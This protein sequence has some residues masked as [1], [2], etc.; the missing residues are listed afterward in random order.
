MGSNRFF[1]A[2]AALLLL[3]S[4][5]SAQKVVSVTIPKAGWVTLVLKDT[6]GR[7]VDQVMTSQ[8]VP[9]AGAL[10]V[11][12]DLFGAGTVYYPSVAGT[13]RSDGSYTWQD[14][15]LTPGTYVLQGVVRD[16]WV[17]YYNAD[18]TTTNMVPWP[19]ASGRGANLADHNPPQGMACFAAP[20]AWSTTRAVCLVTSATAEAGTNYAAFAVDTVWT[21]LWEGPNT[22]SAPA[23]LAVDSADGASSI[24]AYGAFYFKNESVPEG[25]SEGKH[26]DLFTIEDDRDINRYITSV[27]IPGSAVYAG[28]DRG[29]V[30]LAVNNQRWIVALNDRVY[31]FNSSRAITDSLTA[32]LTGLAWNGGTLYATREDGV[33]AAY[34]SFSHA[35]CDLGAAATLVSGLD[36]PSDLALKG[37]SLYVSEWGT[38]NR[39]RVF[40]RSGTAVRQIGTTGALQV[41]TYNPTQMQRPAQV[42]FY[43]DRVC[44]AESEYT[45]KR[46]V[47]FNM[48][49]AATVTNLDGWWYG[50]GSYSP[51][52]VLL[53]ENTFVYCSQGGDCTEWD[54]DKG[55]TLAN[56]ARSNRHP[57]AVLYRVS[58]GLYPDYFEPY[59]DRYVV[60]GT[61][62]FMVACGSS[63][64]ACGTSAVWYLKD[65]HYLKPRGAHGR[66]WGA[67][68][69]TTEYADA[70]NDLD[71]FSDNTV[72]VWS[73]SDGDGVIDAAPGDSDTNLD[74]PA[75]DEIACNLLGSVNGRA[76]YVSPYD[77]A[78]ANSAGAYM[79]PPTVG[80][81]REPRWGAPS[82]LWSSPT[83]YAFN[84]GDA[85]ANSG[86]YLSTSYGDV[87]IGP[88]ATAADR[89]ICAMR[90]PF[91]CFKN[92]V[93]LLRFDVSGPFGDAPTLPPPNQ[94]RVVEPQ[95]AFGPVRI[96]GGTRPEFIWG[97]DTD[98][99]AVCLWTIDALGLGCLRFDQRVAFA[100]NDDVPPEEWYEVTEKGEHWYGQMFAHGDSLYYCGGKEYSGCH[101]VPDP[102]IL[103]LDSTTI[104][105]TSGEIAA[106]RLAA[107]AVDSFLVNWQLFTRDTCAVMVTAVAPR[108]DGLDERPAYTRC[109]ISESRGT[110]GSLA[111][112]ADSLYYFVGI[113]RDAYSL[114][115]PGRSQWQEAFL[116]GGLLDLVLWD[117]IGTSARF[118]M[119]D[120]PSPTPGQDIGVR[121]VADSDARLVGGSSFLY[122]SPVASQ[123]VEDASL[124]PARVVCSDVGCEGV[125]DRDLLHFTFAAGDTL[126]GD[127][128]Y[129]VTDSVEAAFRD[130]ANSY[131]VMVSDA[132]EE[133]TPTDSLNGYLAFVADDLEQSASWYAF[134]THGGASGSAN[135]EAGDVDT[136]RMDITA[137]GGLY[138]GYAASVLSAQYTATGAD[139]LASYVEPLSGCSALGQGG[140]YV[141]QD[142]H[143]REAFAS[144]QRS[145]RSIFVVTRA[146]NALALITTSV[147]VAPS[148]RARLRAVADPVADTV[149]LQYDAGAG[150][151][152]LATESLTLTAPYVMALTSSSSSPCTID[153]TDVDVP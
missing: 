124:Y 28:G 74:S 46:F 39:V 24:T 37:D 135:Y 150:W 56:G 133:S 26:I 8:Y 76:W 3:A 89:I 65:G 12:L 44:V 47:C 83:N 18:A 13:V 123:A 132:P 5:A 71:C 40:T 101:V 92:G 145:R 94:G 122:E 11:T 140:L 127:M 17:S 35:G 50:Q 29:K 70:D 151:Q 36:E 62:T 146:A 31:C 110:Y 142:G 66:D 67:P 81:S 30:A 106:A 33:L 93:E 109:D 4:S 136:L 25:S 53:S 119:S 113:D 130:Y 7:V 108:V 38:S 27:R 78:A 125:F 90:G 96:E 102:E 42:A 34:P 137:A 153:F 107:G 19:T 14:T 141:G 32:S 6:A 85:R 120:A 9:S 64:E 144:I 152:T 80:A 51:G 111:A 20:N 100:V 117:E 95:R 82:K 129:I 97:V 23:A 143:G 88:G 138:A 87:M 2:L 55:D 86:T 52:G 114:T 68:G 21:K 73:D 79:P 58:S 48:S 149:L 134:Q 43:T 45:P 98:K 22:F 131:D 16:R 91:R 41:G 63:S 54:Y 116:D 72:F 115:W 128:G 75:G 126:R 84:P 60:I 103:R 148:V 112:T 10:S 118:L 49:G 15:L 105:I 77:G 139:T 1:S 69:N 57:R 121:I 104:T 147:S 61:D 59:V 99:G